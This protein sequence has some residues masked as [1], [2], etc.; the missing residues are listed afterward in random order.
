MRVNETVIGVVAPVLLYT[1]K[2]IDVE[3]GESLLNPITAGVN[4]T[5]S[6]VEDVKN[7]AITPEPGAGSCV[8]N[9]EP[10]AILLTLSEYTITHAGS[11]T[12]AFSK[13]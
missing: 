10:S 1:L 5:D 11:D 3:T 13:P 7:S 8:I 6:F 9:L 4:K 2:Y 12:N